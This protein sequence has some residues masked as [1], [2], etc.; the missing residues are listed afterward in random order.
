MT[1][2]SIA[3]IAG[4]TAASLIQAAVN[5]SR[6]VGFWGLRQRGCFAGGRG[7]GGSSLGGIGRS[8][9][10]ATATSVA[11]RFTSAALGFA[12]LLAA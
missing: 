5:R 12:A 2:L 11:G 7:L 8:R 10:T 4:D 1:F 9:A 3:L 6:G